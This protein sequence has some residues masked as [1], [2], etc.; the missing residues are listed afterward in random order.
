MPSSTIIHAACCIF[1]EEAD[2][3][4]QWSTTLVDR[5]DLRGSSSSPTHHRNAQSDGAKISNAVAVS[6]LP[7]P[8]LKYGHPGEFLFGVDL[9]SATPSG[10]QLLI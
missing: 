4:E 5:S 8:V 3:Y 2:P 9:G 1:R 10:A 6:T 7:P